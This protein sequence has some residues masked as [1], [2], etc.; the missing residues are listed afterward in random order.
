MVTTQR[1]MAS[2]QQVKDYLAHWFQLG[3]KVLLNDGKQARLPQPIF[4]GDRYSDEFEACW[5]QVLSPESGNC[6]LEGTDQTVT[7]LLTSAW[8]IIDCGRCNMPIPVRNRG[9]QPLS[10][11]CDDLPLWPNRELPQP[12]SVVNNQQ[13]LS[14]ISQRLNQNE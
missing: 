7:D 14:N 4:Q 6:Y 2:R 9:I 12:R 1:F 13:R 3:K 11:P 8:D 10:C 5:Q